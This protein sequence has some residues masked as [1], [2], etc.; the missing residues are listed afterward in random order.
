VWFGEELKVMAYKAKQEDHVS[1]VAADN[2]MEPETLMKENKDLKRASFNMLFHGNKLDGGDSLKIP[3]F[4]K[5]KLSA[6]TGKFNKFKINT[7]KLFLRVRI[8]KD[9]FSP[10]KDTPY[11]LVIEGMDKPF[12][13]KTDK[14]GHI[15]HEIKSG[16]TRGTL[17]VSP[18]SAD[19]DPKG[20]SQSKK[21]SGAL[22]SNVPVTW[23]LRIG[24]LNP[25]KEDN[26]PDKLC[27]S[28]VQQRLNN[29]NFNTGPIDGIIGPNTDAAIKAFQEL[30]GIKKDVTPGIPDQAKT[31]A[32]MQKVHDGKTPVKP[33]DA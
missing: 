25:I 30:A 14:D 8:L 20:E 17:S 24:A 1:K 16:S 18:T 2:G 7:D 3:G 32:K 9:D 13:G 21:D 26:A 23:T 31:Q 19:G 6:A 22:D 12:K 29:M 15:K 5:A 33:I 4:L 28:G 27:V 11:E 10:M